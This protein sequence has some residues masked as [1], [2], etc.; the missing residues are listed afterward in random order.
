MFT[1]PRLAGTAALAVAVLGFAP[2]AASAAPTGP[3]AA[4]CTVDGHHHCIRGG[5]FCSKNAAG[6][7]ATDAKGRVYV[8]K[9]GHWR[10]A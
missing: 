2:T 9:A 3:A 5:E 4:H 6:H 7:K 8:C 1:I 10:K